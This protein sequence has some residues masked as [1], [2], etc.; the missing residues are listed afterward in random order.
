[1]TRKW[2]SSAENTRSQKSS[3]RRVNS[4]Y[5]HRPV[6]NTCRN[7]FYGRHRRVDYATVVKACETVLS[8]WHSGDHSRTSAAPVRRQDESRVISSLVRST[9]QPPS[10]LSNC[11]TCTLTTHAPCTCL[12]KWSPCLDLAARLASRQP[13]VRSHTDSRVHKYVSCSLS[14]SLFLPPP[15][16]SPLAR[17]SRLSHAPGFRSHSASFQPLRRRL[18]LSPS[19]TRCAA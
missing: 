10:T 3:S 18:S 12:S 13:N 1:M 19:F 9:A 17:A 6:R 7:H 5:S 2:V 16:L 4:A 15:C 14:R 8:R 11:R